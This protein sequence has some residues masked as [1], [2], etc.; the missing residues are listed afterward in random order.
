MV[1]TRPEADAVLRAMM[2]RLTPAER[3]ERVLRHSEEMREIALAALRVRHPDESLLQLV[4]RMTGEPMRP[5][6]RSGPVSSA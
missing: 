3:V 6:R 4:E 1:D 2:L 5:Y